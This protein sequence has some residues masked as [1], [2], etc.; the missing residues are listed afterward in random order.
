MTLADAADAFTLPRF[1][2]QDFTLGWLLEVLVSA[3]SLTATQ[4]SDIAAKEPQARARVLKSANTE[5]YVVSPIEIVAAFQIPVGTRAGEVLD[6]DRL[7]RELGGACGP[8]SPS[9]SPTPS[10]L[11]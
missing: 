11:R 5:R 6:Q 7:P 1:E 3:G 4:S 10:P 9:R 8:V 2:Q